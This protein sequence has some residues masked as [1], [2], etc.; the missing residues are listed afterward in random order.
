VEVDL[1]ARED[2]RNELENLHARVHAAPSSRGAGLGMSAPFIPLPVQM[3]LRLLLF[4][5]RV[6]RSLR[7]LNEP[8]FEGIL[9][10]PRVA[11]TGTERRGRSEGGAEA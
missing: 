6:D 3:R 8:V 4:P 11:G 7:F 5:L 10:F 2:H 9:P 1:G